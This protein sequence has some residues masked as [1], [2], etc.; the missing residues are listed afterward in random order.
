ML[1]ISLTRAFKQLAIFQ[2]N[3][4]VVCSSIQWVTFYSRIN[5][6]TGIVMSQVDRFLALHLHAEYKARVS[7]ELAKGRFR[8]QFDC[9]FFSKQSAFSPGDK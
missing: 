8:E 6:Y 5:I 2:L 9:C 4:S 1:D 3:S 7:P